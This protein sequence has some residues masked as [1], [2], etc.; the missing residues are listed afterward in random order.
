M[1]SSLGVAVKH[2]LQP[3]YEWLVY[4]PLNGPHSDSFFTQ[5][6]H[7]GRFYASDCTYGVCL[8]G[9]VDAESWVPLDKTKRFVIAD[10]C[11]YCVQYIVWNVRASVGADHYDALCAD[12]QRIF[13]PFGVSLSDLLAHHPVMSAIRNHPW[14]PDG[15]YKR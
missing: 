15:P 3:R 1:E 14:V 6:A 2:P 13:D 8:N 4:G 7:H 11:P 9:C 12:A 10:A 5:F